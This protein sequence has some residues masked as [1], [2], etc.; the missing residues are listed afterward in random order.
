MISTEN[1]EENVYS[2]YIGGTALRKVLD[3]VVEDPVLKSMVMRQ[4]EICYFSTDE[5]T[6][7]VEECPCGLDMD[8]IRFLVHETKL[9]F[10]LLI[11]VRASYQLVMAERERKRQE[12]EQREMEERAQKNTKSKKGKKGNKEEEP[13]VDEEQEDQEDVPQELDFISILPEHVQ[14]LF[15]LIGLSGNQ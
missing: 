8:N 9:W 12:K 13:Q 14:E 3:D 10:V 1:V 6:V 2:Q 7:M 11:S 4:F 15:E 5:D